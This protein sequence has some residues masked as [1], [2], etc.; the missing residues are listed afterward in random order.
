LALTGKTNK[1]L[2]CPMFPVGKIITQFV[3]GCARMVLG[4]GHIYVLMSAE[5]AK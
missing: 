3:D 4:R 2:R 5:I 1:V